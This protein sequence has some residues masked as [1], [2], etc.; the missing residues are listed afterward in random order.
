MI[1]NYNFIVEDNSIS[2]L[3]IKNICEIIEAD[4]NA[5]YI[6]V[7]ET[8]GDEIFNISFDNDIIKFYKSKEN[9]NSFWVKYNSKDSYFLI[10]KKT[11]NYIKK[12]IDD[13]CR[14]NCNFLYFIY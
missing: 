10:H 3:V 7:G 6:S 13:C 1:I 11:L 8:L 5:E 12:L 14:S 4:D 9:F 2:A